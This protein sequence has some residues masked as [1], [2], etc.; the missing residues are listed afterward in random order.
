MG[1][2]KLTYQTRTDRLFALV[3][4]GDEAAL[5]NLYHLCAPR[6]QAFAARMLADEESARDVIQ[7]TFVKV[8]EKRCEIHLQNIEGY[9]FRV[10][11]NRCLTYLKQKQLVENRKL[12]LGETRQMEELYRIDFLRDEPCAL[13][14]EELAQQIQAVYNELPERCR[15]VFMLSR[16]EGLKN[17]EIAEKLQINIKNVERHIA[18]ALQAFRSRFPDDVLL[19]VYLVLFHA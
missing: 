7:D 19:T 6:L 10:V 3:A 18:R 2:K 8:W 12:R 13:L 15:E 9:L 17:R 14:E 4:A 1:E 11:R 16:V 5:R